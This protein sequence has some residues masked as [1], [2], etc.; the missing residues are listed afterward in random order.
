MPQQTNSH[1]ISRRAY[2]TGTGTAGIIALAGCLGGGEDDEDET[3][4]NGGSGETMTVLHGW[5]GGDGKKAITA[6][7]DGFKKKYPDAKANFNPVG[8]QGNVQLNTQIVQKL[9][10]GNPPSSWAAWPGAHLTQFTGSDLLGDISESVWSKN[11]M[12]D[13]YVEEAKQ[14]SQFNGKFVCVPVGS[15]RMNN[16]FYNVKVLNQAGIDPNELSSPSDLTDALATIEKKTD[17]VG[18]AQSMTN[19]VTII[20]LWAATMLGSEGYQPYM[21]L[22]NG[23]GDV[24]AVKS[25]L[26]AV[27]DLSQ[28]FNEDA[29]STDPPGAMEQVA[30]GEAGVLQTGNWAAGY[31]DGNDL[32]Y[33]TDWGWAPYPGTANMY[34]LHFDSFVFPKGAPAPKMAQ[35]WLRH[36]GTKEA[37]IAFNTRKG[38]IPPRTD[39]PKDEFGP[40]LS[41]MMEDFNSVEHKPPTIADGLAVSPRTLTDLQ[42][43][44]TNNFMG[45]YNVDTTAE[46]IVETINQ[47]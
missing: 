33:N 25:S 14:L 47:G 28:Y 11:G 35:K 3:G 44:F 36:C 16:L 24:K 9:N 46:Q 2:L 29:S 10:N 38:S 43:V 32:K 17:A 7:T 23:N 5:T 21:D 30:N 41:Q 18:M 31:F 40:Y 27:K 12:K 1:T 4:P 37:Q 13:A 26:Q 45:P 20:R 8:G 34:G 15:H 19:S 42:S 6:L 39:V 22:I